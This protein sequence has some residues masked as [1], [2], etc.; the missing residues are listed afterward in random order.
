MSQ[1]NVETMRQSLDAFDRRDRDVW[2][3]LR[4]PDSE[5]VTSDSWP[6]S[7]EVRGCEAAWDF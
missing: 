7:D 1:E 2:L 3:V 4:D 6:E 5:V